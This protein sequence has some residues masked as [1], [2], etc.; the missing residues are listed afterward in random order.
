VA[1]RLR[2]YDFPQLKTEDVMR[3][4][5]SNISIT[6]RHQGVPTVVSGGAGKDDEDVVLVAYETVQQV[7]F[8]DES[9]S[10]YVLDQVG[11]NMMELE[12]C[13]FPAQLAITSGAP[14]MT[15]LQGTC[16]L[17]VCVNSCPILLFSSSSS[18]FLLYFD[19][20]SVN[21]I[22]NAVASMFKIMFSS[23]PSK[24]G[25]TLLLPTSTLDDKPTGKILDSAENGTFVWLCKLTLAC[26]TIS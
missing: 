5:T 17:F 2:H 3:A 11:D 23:S 25:E 1:V 15:A 12:E 4:L 9:S 7:G 6:T 21:G 14:V 16:F 26:T 20:D 24:R 13:L 22:Q 18:L 10:A 19:T 8:L